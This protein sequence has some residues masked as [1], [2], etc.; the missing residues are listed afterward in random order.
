MSRKGTLKMN[1]EQFLIE[2]ASALSGLPD[3]DIGKTL[4]FYSE[5]IEDLIEEG[6]SEE[7]A[8]AAQGTIESIREQIIKEISLP[9]LIKQKVKPKRS[10]S[11]LEITLLIVGFPI[12][13]PILVSVAAVIFSIYVTLWS[14][15]VVLFAVEISFAASA[16]ACAIASIPSFIFLNTPGALFLLGCGL[17]LAGLSVLWVFVCK[18]G[19]KFLIWLTRVFIKSLFI[20]KEKTK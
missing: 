7:E 10:L 6:L 3:D 16:F 13:L 1:K 14:L 20:R 5:M 8:V 17:F 19:V 4:E 9:K 18:W 15:I 12:W 2:L 11:G